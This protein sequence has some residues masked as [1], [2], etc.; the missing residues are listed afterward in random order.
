MNGNTTVGEF[1]SLIMWY[2]QWSKLLKPYLACMVRRAWSP[3]PPEGSSVVYI[4]LDLLLTTWDRG[5]WQQGP[6]NIALGPREGNISAR[7]TSC[8]WRPFYICISYSLCI[9][10]HITIQK[11]N[12]PRSRVS[13]P[14]EESGRHSIWPGISWHLDFLQVLWA[15]GKISHAHRVYGLSSA[16][17]TESL[18]RPQTSPCLRPAS[19]PCLGTLAFQWN[20]TLNHIFKYVGKSFQRAGLAIHSKTLK[21]AYT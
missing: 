19:A 3:P 13:H 9:D 14:G 12:V 5:L 6:E 7:Y 15:L 17:G 2:Q 8:F 20:K 16:Q 4:E 10:W 18:V 1:Y 11:P 21:L